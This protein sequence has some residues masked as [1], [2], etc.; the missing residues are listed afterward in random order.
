MANRY[1]KRCSILL[2]IREMQIKIT[3]RNHLTSVRMTIIKK[4]YFPGGPV[5]QK[6]FS[7]CR[8]PRFD[9]WSGN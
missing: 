8:G 4:K 2:F 9:P 5:A 7:Q 3:V 1:M 6:V